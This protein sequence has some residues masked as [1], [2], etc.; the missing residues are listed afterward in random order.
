MFAT[1]S[2]TAR[3]EP[4][5][6]QFHFSAQR[7]WIND[8]N[9]LIWLDGEYHLFYQYNPFGDEWGHMSWGHA[10]SPDLVDWEELPVAIAEDERVSIFSGSVV[11]D[12]HNSSGFGSDDD[13]VLVAIYTGCLR[14]PEGGQAQELAY[15]LDRGRTWTKHSNNP[16]LDLGLRD[17]R[18]PKVFWHEPSARWI[19]LVVLPDDRRAQFYG[20]VDLKAWQWMSEFDAPLADQGIW[21]CPDLI[22]LRGSE[23][24]PV[25][26]FKVDVL[27]GHPCGGAGARLFFGQ[28]DGTRFIAEP[29]AAPRWADGGA[30]FYAALSW[31]N[32]PHGR[33]IWLAWMNSHRYAKDLPT[34][35]WR[36]AMSVPRELS[37]RRTA[38]GWQLL[39]TPVSELERLR[40][41]DT[42][43]DPQ[44]VTNAEIELLDASDSERCCDIVLA[45]DHCAAPTCGLLL[46]TGPSE[47]TRIGFDAGQQT[48]FVE[49]AAAG[50]H[51]L[52]DALFSARCHVP[53]SAPGAGEPLRLRVLLDR[54]SLE[55]FVGDGEATLTQQIFPV[56]ERCTLALYAQS[57]SA[58]FSA[59]QV[60]PLRSARFTMAAPQEG[61]A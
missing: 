57:G 33:Q 56:G 24:E 32:L 9:G 8:P 23:G 53:C 21:E 42:Q 41:S 52:G 14:R 2:H 49:R 48:V 6:P 16:V 37:A 26:L 12:R 51:P 39:Q 36:G 31:A 17:F 43:F 35:P 58:D 46:R 44:R 4:Y 3:R 55:V 30:D 28:F 13:S 29:E 10:V 50:F 7:H 27:A 54:S 40:R 5:R 22:P 47:F 45:I 61:V 15:S 25:W 20:S 59:V 18:D 60:W 38:Q 34:H 1:P 19:M 11:L